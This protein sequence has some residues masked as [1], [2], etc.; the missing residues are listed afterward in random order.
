MRQIRCLVD[1]DK[2]STTFNVCGKLFIEYYENQ[3]ESV[4]MDEKRLDAFESM[5][6][7]IVSRYDS[8]AEKMAVLKAEG[9]EKTATYRQLFADKL[10][11][12]NI[13]SYYRAYGLLDEK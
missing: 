3:K 8:T 1:I 11:L 13:L 9:K 6:A 12:Q 7:D 10:Q 4:S 5:L 2:R